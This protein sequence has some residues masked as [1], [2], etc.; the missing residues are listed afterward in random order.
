MPASSKRRYSGSGVR[1][2]SRASD[3]ASERSLELGSRASSR[4][5][6]DQMFQ[7]SPLMRKDNKRVIGNNR[8]LED[9]EPSLQD[10]YMSDARN[11]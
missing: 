3:K 5:M 1:T 9:L 10:S 8:D 11:S 7:K 2:H 4:M 6:I